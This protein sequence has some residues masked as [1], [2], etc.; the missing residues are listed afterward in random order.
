M[1]LGELVEQL[2]GAVGAAVIDDDHAVLDTGRRKGREEVVDGR[3]EVVLLAVG[4]H[5]H[6]HALDVAVADRVAGALPA[7]LVGVAAGTVVTFLVCDR[8]VFAGSTG[9]SL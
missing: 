7:A 5:D 3:L 9:E 4:G 1:T 6:R 2:P 8:L